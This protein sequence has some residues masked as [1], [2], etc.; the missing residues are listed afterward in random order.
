VTLPEACTELVRHPVRYVIL[1]W[2]WKSALMSAIVRALLFFAANVGAGPWQAS[3][4]SVVEFALRVPL[5]GTLASVTQ[6][7]R[8]A[9]PAW[10]TALVAMAVLPLVAHAVELMTHTIAGTPRL[11][12]SLLASVTMSAVATTFNLFAMRRGTLL[13]GDDARSLV[14]DVKDLPRLIRLFV[15]TPIAWVSRRLRKADAAP[16]RAPSPR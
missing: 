1:R 12:T 3:R 16:S 10:A 5:V 2:N 15:M 14:A 13:V 8:L 9:D 7:F 6:L 4:A 11:R